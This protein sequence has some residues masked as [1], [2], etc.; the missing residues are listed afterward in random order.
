MAKT[1]RALIE[2]LK[3]IPEEHLDDNLTVYNDEEVEYYPVSL[4][5]TTRD[6]EGVLDE[7][8]PFFDF[9]YMRT[10]PSKTKEA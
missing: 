6:S 4:E 1:Y 3:S 8:H 7:G 10:Y 2:E 5:L 9:D